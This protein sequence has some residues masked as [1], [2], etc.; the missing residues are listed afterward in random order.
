M[1]DEIIRQ[2]RIEQMKLEFEVLK[3]VLTFCTLAVAIE[4]F[5]IGSGSNFPDWLKTVGLVILA[6]LLGLMWRAGKAMLKEIRD[7]FKE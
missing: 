5:I 1:T 3:I 4:V 7:I 2:K 6:V